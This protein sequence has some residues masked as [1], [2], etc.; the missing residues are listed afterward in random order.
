MNTNPTQKINDTSSTDIIKIKNKK[1]VKNYSNHNDIKHHKEYVYHEFC[2]NC[3]RTLCMCDDIE[4]EA[5]FM[6]D[7]TSDRKETIGKYVCINCRKTS[8]KCECL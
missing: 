7:H 8:F 2:D 3:M 6:I 1:V 4:K 5:G